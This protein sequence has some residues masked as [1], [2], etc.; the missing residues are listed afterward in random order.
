MAKNVNP[1]DQRKE[2][3]QAQY[4]LLKRN[5][6]RKKGCCLNKKGLPFSSL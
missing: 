4:D 1:K 6:V 3:N 2:Q 5:L